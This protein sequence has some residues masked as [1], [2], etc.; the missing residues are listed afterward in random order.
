[1][2][3]SLSTAARG[4]ALA[5]ALAAGIAQMARAD[6]IVN[7]TGF[8]SMGAGANIF[9][10]PVA[11]GTP[12][13]LFNPVLLDLAAGD[14]LISDAWGLPGALYDAWNF[15]VGARGSWGSHFVIAEALGEGSFSLLLDAQ[16][17]TDPTCSNH[18]CAWDTQ[19]LARDAFL[20][21]DPFKLHLDHATRVAFAA[22]DY[23]LPDNLG[24]MSVRVASLA[25]TVPAVPEPSTWALFGAG[26]AVAAA[27]HRRRPA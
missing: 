21:T 22:A 12:V 1:M 2:H 23:Y 10:Y 5:A 20:A 6:Q 25:A 3:T 17:K 4:L 15:E 16:G 24:G 11:P 14:Y 18:F 13:S 8:G 9:S 19:A 26:L 27:L 7:I